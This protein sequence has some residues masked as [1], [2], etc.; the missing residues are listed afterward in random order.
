MNSARYFSSADDGRIVGLYLNDIGETTPL[1]SPEEAELAARIRKGDQEAMD[2]LTKAN[3]KFVVSVAKNYVNRGLSLGDLIN[4]GN[5]GLIEAARRFDEKRGYRFISYAVWWIRQRILQAIAEQGS[6]VR[7]PA[8]RVGKQERIAR[9]SS[10]L[11][12]RLGRKPTSDEIADLMSVDVEQVEEA[13]NCHRRVL[14]LDTPINQDE[15]T[16]LSDFLADE[17]GSGPDDAVFDQQ[18]QE[19]LKEVLSTLT[20]KESDVL[21]RYFGLYNG[22]GA[23]LE[24]IGKTLGLTRERVRQIKGKALRKL[25]HSSRAKLLEAYVN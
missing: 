22:E 2:R 20:D 23:T 15:E 14:S 25:R 19:D 9:A 4:E 10:Q 8:S 3:L 1:S 5:L 11:G 21:C 24:E 17:E 6:V 13:L 16:P 18:F 12:T 7:L